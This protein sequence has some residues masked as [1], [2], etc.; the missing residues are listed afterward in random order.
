M[1]KG[2]AKTY[3]KMAFYSSLL[4]SAQQQLVGT[5]AVN[6]YSGEMMLMVLPKL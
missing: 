6:T 2:K 1:N 4:L 3:T 5:G